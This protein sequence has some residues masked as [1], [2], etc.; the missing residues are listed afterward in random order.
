MQAKSSS[1]TL[2]EVH[3]IDEGIY[4]NIRLETQVKKPIITS[5]PKG[6]SQVKPRLGQDVAG[7]K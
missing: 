2:P 1:I 6:I 3:G 7:I 4:P 5:E